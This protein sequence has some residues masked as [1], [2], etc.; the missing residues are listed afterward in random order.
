[1]L[2]LPCP[3][4]LTL[5]PVAF[6]STH[7]GRMAVLWMGAYVCVMNLWLERGS[8]DHAA[9][10][11]VCVRPWGPL[12]LSPGQ[13]TSMWGSAGVS[14]PSDYTEIQTLKLSG[15]QG[16]PWRKGWS[17]DEGVTKSRAG[18]AWFQEVPGKKNRCRIRACCTGKPILWWSQVLVKWSIE[19]WGTG[20]TG[21]S[22]IY[23][24]H[25]DEAAWAEG[26]RWPS[27]Y[28]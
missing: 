19:G 20:D 7:P 2:Y 26:N 23:W 8:G 3:P 10:A 27:T 9:S 15:G 21:G 13:K 6:E 22:F 24:R 18:C 11:A 5:A 4:V 16:E 1:M 14:P 17:R 28:I 12:P 25:W